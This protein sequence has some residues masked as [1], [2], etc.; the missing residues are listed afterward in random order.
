MGT[1]PFYQSTE[2]SETF[3]KASETAAGVV[4]SS[5]GRALCR[6]VPHGLQQLTGAIWP[7]WSIHGAAW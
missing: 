7:L 5:S 4:C 6:A 3:I 2:T 1:L